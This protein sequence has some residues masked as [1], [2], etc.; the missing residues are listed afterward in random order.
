MQMSVEGAHGVYTSLVRRP[1][2]LLVIFAALM[3]VGLIA[4]ARIP[5]QMMP[6]GLVEPGLGVWCMHPGASAQENEDKVARVLEEQLRTLAGIEQIQ[7]T[8]RA[9]SVNLWVQFD[10]NTDMTLAKA[11]V[12]DR[13]ERA[14]ALLPDTVQE[15]SVNSWSNDSMPIAFFAILHPGDSSRTDFLIDT[16]IKR[17][18]EAVD[19]VGNLEVWGVLDDSM[20]ILLDEERV[21]GANLDLGQL[22]TRLSQ[23]NFA[24]PL[25]EVTDGGRR[26]MLRSDMRFRSPQEIEA[27]P[28]GGGLTIADVG[29]VE[30]VKS[31]RNRL[32]KIDGSYAYYGEVQK[33]SQANVVET[34]L[35]L[36]DSLAELEADPRL[37]GKFKFLVL[38]DQGQFISASLAQLRDAGLWGG[39]L[40][41]LVLFAFL[42]R[43]RSTLAVALSIPFSVLVGIAWI[44]FGGGSFNVLTMTGITLAMGMLV[45]NSVVVIENIA[46]LR[47]LGRSELGAAAEGT[48]EVAL[49]VLLSTLTTIVV[50]LPMIFMTESPM[51]RIMFGEL[52]RPLCLTL[53]FSLVGALV[54]LPVIAGR[55]VGPRPRVIE[56][57]AGWL[58]PVASAPARGL[59]W[60][61]TWSSR[62]LDALARSARP[63]LHAL[64]RGLARGRWFAALAVL[65]LFARSVYVQV[66]PWSAEQ[67]LRQHF[68][69]ALNP[70]LEDLLALLAGVAAPVVALI[71]VLW[72]LPRAV[73]ALSLAGSRPAREVPRWRSLIEFSEVTH[74]V[75]MRWSLRHRALAA[76][77]SCAVLLSGLWPRANM[78]VT[79]F[80][81]DENTG[82]INLAVELED[83]FTLA[84][85]EREMRFYEGFFE[86]RRE[87]MGFDHL[88]NRFDAR[89]G[90]VSLY[91]EEPL[92]R[93]RYREVENQIR[94]ELTAPPGHKARLWSDEGASA[95]RSKT[96]LTFRLVGQDSEELERLAAQGVKLLER[97]PGLEGVRYGEDDS[98][99]LGQVR[100]VFD[101]DIAQGLGISAESALRNIAWSLRGWQLPRYQED[102]REIPLIIE[103]DDEEVAGLNTLRELSVFNGSSAVPLSSFAQFEFGRGERQIYR[104]NGQ[105]AATIQARVSDPLRQ[106]ELSD[107]GYAALKQL[108][109][110]RGYSV[111][112]EDLVSTRQE[113]ELGEL[114]AALALSTVLVY[115][116]MA[117]LFESLLLPVSVMFTVPY[118]IVGS[119]WTLYATGTTMDS[120][121]WI[122]IIILVG[123]VVNNGIVLIDCVQRMRAEGLARDQAV[124]VGCARRIRP[125][126]MTAMTTVIGLIPTAIA[127]PSS[128]GIDYRALATCVAGGLAFA[129]LFTLWVVPLA[130]T[131]LDDLA[132]AFA[133]EVSVVA[134]AFAP[135]RAAARAQLE[136]LPGDSRA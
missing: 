129:T 4:Y 65:A 75:V 117:I 123:V 60:G 3:V 29:H 121:G 89:G 23:D 68:S 59:A 13:V 102:G 52:G 91:W 84:Q 37:E 54:F 50:F 120:V 7:S 110:P 40:A 33:E 46:R 126:M 79:P 127:E 73:Q 48:R 133:G 11:E 81:E 95:E 80:G 77:L 17:R 32:F 22:I 30:A 78:A 124:V 83:N 18:L 135:R 107:I 100:V 15:I 43:V 112:D 111:G 136:A 132:L 86:A 49:A 125:V 131:L 74:G 66:Q 63:G 41:V 98:T 113:E 105:V 53:M 93:E 61:S 34:C 94:R 90:R 76:A 24:L 85:A 20:R 51:L 1:V 130:Y 92:P 47:A 58:A 36:R 106:K 108:E 72:F 45:D 70:R 128:D 19:G 96:L 99:A 103:V 69:T 5:I 114:L 6:D 62:A 14:R 119:F 97:I 8:S 82:R 42:R 67:R 55:A 2:A 27:Y 35:R 115:V 28:I 71:C 101:P 31:V 56:R 16:V 134:R 21:R 44:Y 25:G 122:G 26:V 9:D 39:G 87:S 104:R 38:F 64:A 12:R 109:L 57:A 88:A 118:A 10:A 116:I